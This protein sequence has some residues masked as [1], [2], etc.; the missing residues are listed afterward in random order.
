MSGLRHLGRRA[1]LPCLVFV[2]CA[3]AYTAAMGARV[4]S[5]SKD[6]HFVYLAESLLNGRLS[7]M[8][9]RPPGDNDWAKYQD[10]WYVSFPPL[11][12]VV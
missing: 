6:P 10:K 2:L 5:T 8:E 4:K 1:A 12:A 3:S 11:P 7:I 9:K